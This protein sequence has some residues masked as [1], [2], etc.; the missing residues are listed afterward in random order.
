M[1]RGLI[2][3]VGLLVVIVAAISMW[4]TPP[5]SV[6]SLVAVATLW[7]MIGLGVAA[8]SALRFLMGRAKGRALRAALAKDRAGIG[9]TNDDE[10]A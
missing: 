2:W 8:N 7:C 5:G 3:L 4:I 9:G 1:M 6:W 10:D